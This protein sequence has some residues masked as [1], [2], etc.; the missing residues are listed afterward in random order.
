MHLVSFTT[1]INFGKGVSGLILGQS[2][3]PAC[4]VVCQ[5]KHV[6]GLGTTIDVLLLDG[7]LHEGDNIVLA[8]CLP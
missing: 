7:I 4:R 3:V 2:D 6:D 1:I 5:V 8:G